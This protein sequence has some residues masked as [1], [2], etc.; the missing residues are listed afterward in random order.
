MKKTLVVLTLVAGIFSGGLLA[1]PA[2]ADDC[3]T[4]P[5]ATGCPCQIDPN[6]S[7]CADLNNTGGFTLSIQNII[8]ILI[9]AIGIVAV[10]MIV[11]S[12]IRFV[13]SRGKPD[14]TAKARTTLVY[15]IVGLVVA[16]SAFAIVNFVFSRL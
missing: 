13:V 5:T 15:S 4:N 16:V 11:V 1:T 3:A 2:L 6:A 9:F 7:I 10:V 8:N 14:E 12:G